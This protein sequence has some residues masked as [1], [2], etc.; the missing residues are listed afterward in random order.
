MALSLF[1]MIVYVPIY[2]LF[3]TVKRRM[4]NAV[5]GR[6]IFNEFMNERHNNREAASDNNAQKFISH[7]ITAPAGMG[8]RALP[9]LLLRATRL[10]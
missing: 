6:V 5:I 3:D 4:N 8:F 7:G 1:V 2:F 9:W 10:L